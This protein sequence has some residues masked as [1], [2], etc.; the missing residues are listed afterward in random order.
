MT[1][2]ILYVAIG[3]SGSGKS[4]VL[5]KLRRKNPNIAHFSWDALR[6]EWYDSTDYSK[7][8]ELS[9]LDKTFK[10]KAD[11]YFQKLIHERPPRDV[12]IDNT[13]LTMKRRRPFIE[14]A[15]RLGYKTVAITFNIDLKTLISRQTTRPDKYVPED[16]VIKQ[17]NNLQPPGWQEFDEVIESESIRTT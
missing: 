11:A 8:F 3:P 14:T 7:A 4:T 1:Q 15:K 10:L 13:N 9:C 5:Q 17:Y 6:L 12:Y 16:A 2:P